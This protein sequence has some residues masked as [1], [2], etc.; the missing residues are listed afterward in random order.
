MNMQDENF[1][2]MTFSQREGFAPLPEALSK[3]FRNRVWKA[4]DDKL[5]ACTGLNGYGEFVYKDV[6]FE[7]Y[8]RN[9]WVSFRTD[10]LEVPHD[11]IRDGASFNIVRKWLRGLIIENRELHEMLT[12]L[13]HMFRGQG[14]PNDLA[15]AI[16]KCFELVPYIVDRTSQPP[17]VFP[18]SSRRMKKVVVKNRENINASKLTNAQIHL[19]RAERALSERNFAAVVRQSVNAVEAAA[20]DIA[21]EAKNKPLGKALQILEKRNIITRP[22]LIATFEKLYAY[23][24]DASDIRHSLKGGKP[25]DVR[26]DEALFIYSICLSFTDY[27]AAKQPQPKENA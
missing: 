25:E 3:R 10:I 26:E 15:S 12:L 20:R 11:E 24:N 22:L 23:A 19:S 27:L 8:L 1:R 5:D 4:I 9:R 2:K 16:E 7:L 6:N 18:V 14:M 17:C 21:P 13:E